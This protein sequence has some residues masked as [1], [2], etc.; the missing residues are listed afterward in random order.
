M[1]GEQREEEEE[2]RALHAGFCLDWECCSWS[3]LLPWGG[4][5]GGHPCQGMGMS[6]GGAAPLERVV[7]EGATARLMELCRRRE[8][9]PMGQMPRPCYWKGIRG[10]LT[11]RSGKVGAE[12]GLQLVVRAR[13]VVGLGKDAWQQGFWRDVKRGRQEQ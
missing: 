11:H 2:V 5:G 1:W 13:N 7:N 12:R 3:C 6:K 9:V 8:A 4:P 10:G